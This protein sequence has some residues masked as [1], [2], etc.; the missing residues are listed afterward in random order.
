V[1]FPVKCVFDV[2]FEFLTL[3]ITLKTHS[4]GKRTSK[5]HIQNASV[6]NPLVVCQEFRKIAD[7]L[8]SCREFPD[9]VIEL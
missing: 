8:W 5:L 9:N 7:S 1:R 3:K 4:T 6:I 2:S